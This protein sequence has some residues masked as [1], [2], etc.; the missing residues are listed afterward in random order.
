MNATLVD[1][2]DLPPV[3]TGDE[4]VLM[5]RSDTEQITADDIAA[6][7]ETISYEVLCQ[8]GSSNVRIFKNA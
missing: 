8:F 1:V 3:R 4:V 6:W 5:G 2:T 7:M